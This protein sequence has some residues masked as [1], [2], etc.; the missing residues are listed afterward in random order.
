[1]DTYIDNKTRLAH[2]YFL[3]TKDEQPIAYKGYEAWVE[4]HMGARIKILNSDHG[5]EYLGGDFV[6]YLKSRGTLQKLSVH[7]THP[8]SV[9]NVTGY[10]GVFQGNPYPYPSKPVPAPTGM[11]FTGMGRGFSQTRGQIY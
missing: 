8:E 1:M 9:G 11:G 5:G 6:A 4:N 2:V 7:D 3:R 10:P